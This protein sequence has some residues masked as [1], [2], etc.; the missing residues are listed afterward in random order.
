MKIFDSVKFSPEQCKKELAAFG[1]L[2]AS[3]ADLHETHDVRPFFH[4]NP[5]L[6]ALVGSYNPHILRFDRLATEFKLAGAH[7]CDL[8][9][10]DSGTHNYC[11]VEFEDASPKSIF[12]KKKGRSTPEWSTRFNHGYSQIID[13][14]F[15]LEDLRRTDLWESMF[16]THSIQYNALLVIGRRASLTS[17]DVARVMWRANQV[18][19]CSRQVHCVTFDDLYDHLCTKLQVL[20]GV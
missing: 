2:L 10:G 5:Q 3:K 16:G 1:D 9:I 20:C 12:V 18:M 17:S 13:W 11:F 4:G 19:I 8:V 14:Y 6:A 7:A 15:L